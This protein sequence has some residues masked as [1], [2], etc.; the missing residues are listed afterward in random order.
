M[1]HITQRVSKGS[2][3]KAANTC[4][5]GVSMQVQVDALIGVI[6]SFIEHDFCGDVPLK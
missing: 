1:V 4:R 6:G 3:H 5:L 2:N